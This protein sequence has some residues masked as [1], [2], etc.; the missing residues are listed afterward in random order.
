MKKVSDFLID[1]KV[2][3]T[4]KQVQMVL[5]SGKDIVWLVGHRIDGRYAVKQN[6]KKVYF[7]ILNN[8]KSN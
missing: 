3:L 5:L 4:E 1:N 2:P 7:V 6:T 8:M